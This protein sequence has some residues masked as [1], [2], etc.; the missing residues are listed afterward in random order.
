MLERPCPEK[1]NLLT[2]YQKAAEIYAFTVANLTRLVGTAP[3]QEYVKASEAAES[4]RHHVN[5]IRQRLNAHV[6]AHGC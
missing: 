1:T 2:E 6:D 4:Q 3:R 5:G